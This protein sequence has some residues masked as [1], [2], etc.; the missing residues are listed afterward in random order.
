MLSNAASIGSADWI[1][2]ECREDGAN[3][4]THQ[5]SETESFVGRALPATVIIDSPAVSKK[6]A[7]LIGKP[8]GLL[9]RDLGSTNGTF[10]NGI[11]IQERLCAEG[12]LIQFAKVTFRV[13]RAVVANND[14][15]ME[16][17]ALP[18]AEALLQFDLLMNGKG[19][20]PV[21]QPIIDLR[22]QTI[23]AYELLARSDHDQLRHPGAMFGFAS[24]LG[25]EEQ[26]SGL[27]RAEGAR[28]GHAHQ[29][30][31]NLFVNTHPKEVVTSRFLDSLTALREKHP[32]MIVTVEIHEAAITSVDE[33]SDLKKFLQA[34]SM[35]LAYDDFGAGQA[36]L[37]ELSQI[38]PDYLKFD[39]KLI[40]DIDT[41]TVAR[42]S[43]IRCL[44]DMA[45]GLGI[46]TLAEGIETAGEAAACLE[47]GFELAQGFHFG[48]PE[49]LP[50]R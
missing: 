34:R 48:R 45:K 4:R 42:R 31:P 24:L 26:L 28:I 25:Q 10:V 14:R 6:H 47:L 32:D 36:R 3:P 30:C 8:E 20:L 40:R 22:D 7:M 35:K 17:G 39:I 5:L 37:D 16:G 19:L 27:V 41:A 12:D 2:S 11:R 29:T 9:L 44:V 49:P 43:M 23:V 18:H 33:M 1:L 21:F 13:G 38:P 15:T 46:C 50:R